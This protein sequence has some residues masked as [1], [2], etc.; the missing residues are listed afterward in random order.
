MSTGNSRGPGCAASGRSQPDA[1]TA[2]APLVRSL[3]ATLARTPE[4]ARIAYEIA[5]TDEVTVPFERSDLAEALGNLLENATRHA[6][7][8]VRIAAAADG[9]EIAVEDDGAGIAEAVRPMVLAR[10]GRLD[11]RGGAGLGLAIVQDVVEAY[12]WTLRLDTSE[13]GGLR[14]TIQPT[15]N[16]TLT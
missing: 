2:L 3:V 16:Q 7:N 9:R 11:Q 13:L 14:A 6:R 5:M 12:G 4:G 10:G 1:S 8:R 15:V